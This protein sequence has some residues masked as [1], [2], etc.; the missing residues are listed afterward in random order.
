[1]SKNKDINKPE[2]NFL[3]FD[4]DN[5][6]IDFHTHKSNFRKTWKKYKPKDVVLTYNTGRLIDDVLNLIDKGVLPEPDYIISGVGTHIYNYKDKCIVKEFNN[7]LDD[8][9]DL[10][11]VEDLIQNIDHPIS[12][13]PTKF[14]HAYKRSYFFHNASPE[15]IT[16]VEK[17]FENANMSINVVYSGDKFLDILPKFA[18]KGNALQWLTKKLD[19]KPE[20][21]IVAG[22]SGND[23][24]MFDLPDVKGI[25]VANAHEELY[26]YTK[27][28]QVYHTEKEKSDGIIE[29]L[30]YYG[31]LP[32]AA[33]KDINIDHKDDFFIKQESESLAAEDADEKV[34]LIREGY[35]KAVLALKK[36]ITPL[37]FSACSIKDNVAH[38]TDENYYSV[39]ARDGAITVIGALPLIHKDEEIHKCAR[40][41]LLTLFEH[42]SRNGQIPSNVRIKDNI[43]DYSG[44]GGICSIDSGIWVVIAFYEY[45]N[46]TKD[47]EF[48][49]THISDI[50][51]TMRWLGAHDS[52]NDAL[53]EIPEAG[54]W[55]DLFGRSYN[56]L[57]DEILWYRA[58]VCFGRMMEM[59]GDHEEAGEH[60][61]WSQVIKKEILQ[62]FWPSTKQQLFQSVSFAEKQFTLGDTSYL[63]AQT[64]P[65]DFSWRCDT[66]GNILAFLHGTIDAEKAHQTFKF[67]WGVGVN[68]PFPV[69][70]VYPVVSPGDPDWR[71]YYTVNLL[72]LPNHYHNGGIWPF[73][74]GFWV[75]FVNKLGFRDIAIAELHK[76]ALINKEGINVEWEFTE[77]AH[78]T[79]GK[80]MGK[81]YQAWSA[82]QYISACHDLKII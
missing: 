7:V 79:T 49:R 52:N 39:W 70:N 69:A 74:G 64:T 5:T 60:I 6:L 46:E 55:T 47:I 45:V 81:A 3:S 48:L 36:N 14:Q 23:S 35:E 34:A 16:S 12:D 10:K 30:V 21:V 37:G 65:F 17:D 78:G 71:P 19:I 18:N 28:R 13:Q 51:E 27:H 15:L 40:Q 57:Y 53:L 82:A 8:G 41:T 59:L 72:N 68:D 62:N 22:D 11:A 63:I 77:W 4:I 25:V 42:I 9:W 38:G 54:D 76:L 26:Q 66:L 58:N 50:K 67:M 56:I 73:V 44:V 29:G 24:A 61:R 43:P 1:M 20:S 33:I 31:I 2:I 80:P 32:S 75:K